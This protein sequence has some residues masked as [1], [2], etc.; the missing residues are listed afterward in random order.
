M[1]ILLGGGA[2]YIG[3]HICIDLLKQDMM[4]SSLTIYPIVKS[5]LLLGLSELPSRKLDL[6]Y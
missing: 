1:K 6:S 4:W 5:R 3:S 2:G